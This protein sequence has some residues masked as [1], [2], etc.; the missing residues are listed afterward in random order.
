MPNNK[1][2]LRALPLLGLSLVMILS[3]TVLAG[4]GKNEED[5]NIDYTPDVVDEP[6]NQN[7]DLTQDQTGLDS[8]AT[9]TQESIDL[10]AEVRGLDDSLKNVSEKDLDGSDVNEKALGL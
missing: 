6:S 10:D 7:Q 9:T 4:C 1:N 3:L 5:E 8:E 2:W